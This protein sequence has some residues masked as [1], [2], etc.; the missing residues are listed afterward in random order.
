MGMT[1]GTISGHIPRNVGSLSL[2]FRD[3]VVHV[4]ELNLH[5]YLISRLII[6]LLL[7]GDPYQPDSYVL[8]LFNFDVDWTTHT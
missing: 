4:F 5:F 8:Q 1:G 7:R 3:S 2:D 6:K